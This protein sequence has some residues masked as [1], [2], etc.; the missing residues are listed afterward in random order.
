[1]NRQ[2]LPELENFGHHLTSARIERGLSQGSLGGLCGLSQARISLFE[3]GHGLPSL[4]QFIRLARVLEI[5]LQR[6]IGGENRPGEQLRDIAIELHQLGAVDLKISD[7]VV[8]GAARRPEE[9]I[10]LAVSGG[11]PNP[12]II[13]TIPALLSW[14][15]FDPEILRAFGTTSKTI[16]R[17]AWLADVAISIDRRQA[18]PGGCQRENLE[19]FIQELSSPPPGTPWDD[20]GSPSSAGSPPSPV[21]ARWRISYGADIEAF[22]QR[23]ALLVSLFPSARRQTLLGLRA[24]SNRRIPPV[25][26]RERNQ[27]GKKA[28]GSRRP[29]KAKDSPEGSADDKR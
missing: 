6:L 2:K 7:A 5:P 1:M 25:E 28:R 21:W 17:L 19:R 18:F 3:A 23:A 12:R 13:E 9:T 14:N 24:M 15:T 29:Q 8:P 20:L 22:A 26:R 4:D 11:E 10:A 27:T 16:Y